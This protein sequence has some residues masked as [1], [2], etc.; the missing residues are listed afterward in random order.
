MKRHLVGLGLWE[1]IAPSMFGS[2]NFFQ[3]RGV[4]PA[5]APHLGYWPLADA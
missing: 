4:Y 3:I 2:V 1:A 5:P